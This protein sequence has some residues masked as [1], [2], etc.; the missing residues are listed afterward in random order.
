MSEGWHSVRRL[1]CV[2]LDS[3]GDVL[4]TT[5][6]MRAFR[7]SLGCRITLL[8]SAAGATAAPFVPE[9]DEVIVF[10]APWMKSSAG[11]PTGDAQMIST[12]AARRFDAAA[13]F[14]VYS[15]NPLPAAYLCYLA[16]IPRRL[17]HCRENPY[18]LLTD[19]VPDPEP[20]T[21]V[22]H[23]VRRQL[24]LAR[25]VGC[26]TA[27]ERLS[28][29]VPPGA[30]RRL[31]RLARSWA[32]PLVVVHPGASAPSRRYPPE[33]YARAMDL[34]VAQT[35]CEAVFTGDAAEAE[36]V[37]TVRQSMREASRSLVGELGLHE[38][39]ALID[40][41]DVLVSN[42]TGPAHIAAALGTPVVDLYALTNPQHTPWQVRARVLN[43]DVPCRN[44][45]KSVCP[46]GHHDCL[47]KV[48][49]E[50]VAAAALELL[51]ESHEPSREARELA[52]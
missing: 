33:H 28:F 42:N 20:E 7:Q 18:Q 5:P 3:L 37:Q 45:Y 30:K 26:T 41:A 39:G 38:L 40:A 19:W 17:A 13:I 36:L 22:R 52:A 4:M 8:T 16:G 12:L 43:H 34:L 14:T 24:D 6:A 46:A 48:A 27:D 15:Q 47:R 29:R 23:E 32:R 35:G 31:A 1:L 51:E 50:R 11:A 21:T 25:A 9:I 10:A 49:P 2:R 44:C